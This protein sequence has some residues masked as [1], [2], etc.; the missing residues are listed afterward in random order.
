MRNRRPSV[1]HERI[2]LISSERNNVVLK[3]LTEYLTVAQH[4]SKE[5][6]VFFDGTRKTF[7]ELHSD[8]V[9]FSSGLQ[10]LRLEKN[11]RIAIFAPTCYEWLVAKYAINRAGCVVVSRCKNRLNFR[12][13]H[14]LRFPPLIN[15]DRAEIARI[16][17]TKYSIAVRKE[18]E[19]SGFFLLMKRDLFTTFGVLIRVSLQNFSSPVDDVAE[20]FVSALLL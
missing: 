19:R 6:C 8:V 9:K 12:D 11:S 2:N 13:T 16:F 5:A 15:N 7:K 10:E 17:L 18:I 1:D 14:T 3:R 20:L 4:E